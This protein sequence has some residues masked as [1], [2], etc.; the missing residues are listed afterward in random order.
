MHGAGTDVP[1]LSLEHLRR[2][3]TNGFFRLRGYFKGK[4]Q[5]DIVGKFICFDKAQ[6]LVP[7]I[8]ILESS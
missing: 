3:V 2:L 5:N 4:Q 8:S 7:L 6:I 1:E